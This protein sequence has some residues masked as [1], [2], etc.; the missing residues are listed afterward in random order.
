M[1]SGRAFF[2]VIIVHDETRM[3]DSRNPA[4]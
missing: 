3:N 2:G 1:C 4:E